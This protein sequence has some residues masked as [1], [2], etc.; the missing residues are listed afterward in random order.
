MLNDRISEL[1]ATRDQATPRRREGLRTRFNAPD[2]VSH[3]RRMQAH[4]HHSGGYRR[5]SSFDETR[6]DDFLFRIPNS[7][8]HV[9]RALSHLARRDSIATS[10]RLPKP[11]NLLN[12]SPTMR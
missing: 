11:L 3:L 10:Y 8:L 7:G 5:E 12:L 1:K 9:C 2:R 4:R 6:F